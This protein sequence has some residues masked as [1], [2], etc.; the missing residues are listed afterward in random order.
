MKAW[1]PPVGAGDAGGAGGPSGAGEA[2]GVC[3]RNI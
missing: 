1:A 2:V 3:R